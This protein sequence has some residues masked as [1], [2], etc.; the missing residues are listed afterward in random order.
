MAYDIP[1]EAGAGLIE[2]RDTIPG[3]PFSV[4]SGFDALSFRH[5]MY[6]GAMDP[7]IMVDHFV[8][9]A[10]TFGAHAHA[11]LSA[12]SILFEDSLGQFQNTD[13]LGNDIDLLPGDL[14]WM[15]AGRGAV[16]DE[17]PRSDA[18]THA[19]QVFVNLP[20]RMKYDAPASLHVKAADMPVLTGE[21][22]R[23]RLMLGE[24]GGVKGQSSP[25][26]PMTILDVTL[27]ADGRF[28]HVIPAGQAVFVLSID[29]RANVQSGPEASNLNSG[30]SAAF[31][32]SDT[33]KRLVLT[34]SGRAHFAI[35]QAEPINEPFVQR[36]PFAM[37][38]EAETDAMFAAHEAGKLGR[39]DV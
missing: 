22:Y 28:E 19:L 25:A 16:H 24:T 33:D 7:L 26:L 38:T 34:A 18:R 13:S 29:G 30:Q 10:P 6:D 23:A 21:G 8:M 4:G 17:K 32:A 2:R 37:S 35:L 9:T 11:G 15:K 27:E 39:I 31:R 12:V 36:G 5:G 1:T 14:Y 3:N 20:A